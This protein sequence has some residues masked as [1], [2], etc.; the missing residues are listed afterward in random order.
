MIFIALETI[1]IL[2]G[3]FS[4]LFLT[5]NTFIGLKIACRYRTYR[6]T[7]LLLVGIAWLGMGRPWLASSVSFINLLFTGKGIS[8]FLY[9]ILNF[10]M[11]SI[12]VILWIIAINS[13]IKMRG[14]K[15]FFALFLIYTIIFELVILFYLFTNLEVLAV[16]VNPVDMD[17]GPILIIYL[18]VNLATFMALGFLFAAK[19]LKSE[20]QEVKLK[21]R[22]LFIAFFLFL[23]GAAFEILVS[24]PPNRLILVVSGIIFYI[25]FTMPEGVKKRLLKSS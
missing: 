6:E 22:F 17:L 7:R 20:K 11:I 10:L 13:L 4:I 18:F 14:F 24:F 1:V 23:I 9:I 12:F 15:I 8:A 3:I 21:G 16:F 25:G 5:I 2:N 19:S